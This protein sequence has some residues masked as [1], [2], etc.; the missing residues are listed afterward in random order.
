MTN[1]RKRIRQAIQD[2]YLQLALERSAN[3]YSAARAAGMQSVDFEK[4]RDEVRGI[5]ERCISRLPELFDRFKLEAEQVNAVVYEANTPED[6]NRYIAELAKNRGV[7]LIVKSKS[8][9]TE[10]IGLNAHLESA[11]MKVIETD[12]G[13]WIIQLAH[14]KPSHFTQPAAHKTREE[15]AELFSKVVG[16]KLEPN[17]PDLVEV[18][19]TELRR[20]FVEAQMG[21]SGA[22]IAIAETGSLVIVTNEGNSRLVTTLPPIHVAVVGREKLVESLDDANA[23]IKLLARS[24]TGQKMTAYVSYITGP[25][26]TTDIEKTLA[27]G[28]HG[29]KELHIVFVDNGRSEMREDEDCAEALYCLKCGACLNVCPPYRAVGGHVYGN[30]YIGGIGAVVTSFHR[31]ID[32]AE[33]TLGLCNGCRMCVSVC[34][35]EIDTPG[36]T[37]ALR[38]RIVDKRGLGAADRLKFRMFG[39]LA[40]LET[41]ARMARAARI[42]ML[43]AKPFVNQTSVAPNYLRMGLAFSGSPL[44]K[45]IPN[46]IKPAGKSVARAAFFAGCLIDA[47]YPEIGEA[48][49]DVLVRMGVEVAFPAE[50]TCCGAPMIYAGDRETA[51]GLAIKNVAALADADYVITAC[52]TCAV[53]LREDMTRLVKGTEFEEQ[54]RAIA[55]KVKDFNEFLLNVLQAGEGIS[56]LIASEEK[57][58][59]TYHDPCH[60]KRGLG[61]S[62]E[63][64]SMLQLAGLDLVE[65]P[66]SDVCCG[67]AGSYSFKYPD[68][69]E[70]ILRRKIENV[71]SVEPQIVAT[72]CPGCVFHLRGGMATYSC[73]AQVKHTA[74]IIAERLKSEP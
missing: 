39:D 30:S 28:V 65:M 29:P 45:R 26:R 57:A 67:F 64:R 33:E 44:R 38:E 4:Q 16:R 5:K 61:I 11:G 66:E 31:N 15:I 23:I 20:A 3:A 35:A 48:V 34:P 17:I 47:M 32:E 22:N 13:E 63:P 1:Q 49:C 54:S 55:A 25:S 37:I 58:R 69:S 70:S 68:I 42:P 36:M 10:E 19:R 8:M 46:L 62:A 51:K 6:A 40:T 72:D 24:G 18:A 74:E 9:L 41:A 27:L 2:P 60:L 71:R 50:Q 52:P 7:E 43:L 12:L 21:I 73:P 53:A 56:A 59:V 14:E